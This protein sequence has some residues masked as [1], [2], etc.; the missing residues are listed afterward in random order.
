MKEF[1]KID[2]NNMMFFYKDIRLKQRVEVIDVLESLITFNP[3]C[4][5]NLKN[6]YG[7]AK[8]KHELI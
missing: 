3:L 4:K 6:A 1:V 7:L 5:I 8:L 2:T